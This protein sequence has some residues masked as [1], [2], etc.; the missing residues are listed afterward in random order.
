MDYWLI[1]EWFLKAIFLV[2]FLTVGFAYLTWFERRILARF[3]VRIGPN[4]AGWEG[5]L[6]PI[7]DAVKLIFK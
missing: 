7:S 3:Q 5:L 2:L 6:Q 4:R 1:L